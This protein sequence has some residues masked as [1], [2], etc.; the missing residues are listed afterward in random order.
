MKL[1]WSFRAAND[2]A[3]QCE[4][5]ILSPQPA[6]STHLTVG[7]FFIIYPATD[8][9]NPGHRARPL[10]VADKGSATVAQRSKLIGAPSRNEFWAP[11]EGVYMGGNSQIAGQSPTRLACRLGRCFCRLNPTEVSTGD[12]PPS[13]SATA[14]FDGL[15]DVKSAFALLL[16]KVTK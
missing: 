9:C 10:P 15:M 3:P 11:Q 13:E 14:S 7:T 8:G 4:S 12:P 5:Q 1:R 2:R 6:E 16:T